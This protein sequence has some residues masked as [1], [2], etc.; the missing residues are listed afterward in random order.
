[1]IFTCLVSFS[2]L[3][4]HSPCGCAHSI[5]EG[6]FHIARAGR[7]LELFLLIAEKLPEVRFGPHTNCGRICP[8]ERMLVKLYAVI[9]NTNSW[10]TRFKPRTIT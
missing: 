4:K 7:W 3:L 1:M 6:C 9:V 8:N 2:E 10:S 5:G